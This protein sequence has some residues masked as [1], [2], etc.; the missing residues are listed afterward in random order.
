[1]YQESK[2]IDSDQRMIAL[3]HALLLELYIQETQL[4]LL[5]TLPAIPVSA[6][7]AIYAWLFPH[8]ASGTRAAD[9]RVSGRQ[10]GTPQKILTLPEQV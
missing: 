8:L 7:Y 1:M 5:Y 6:L 2:Y 9:Y 3:N 4:L 10:R